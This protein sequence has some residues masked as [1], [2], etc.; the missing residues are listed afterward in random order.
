MEVKL[1]GR[2]AT[3]RLGEVVAQLVCAGDVVLL[4]GELGAGKTTFVRGLVRGLGSSEEVTSPTFTLRHEYDTTPMLTHVDCWRLEDVSE[5][6]DL[7]LD[8]VI[9]EGGLL[10]IEWGELA[11][12]RFGDAALSVVLVD[13]DAGKSR[14]ATLELD[15]PAWVKRAA[16][17]HEALAA[18]G[19]EPIGGVDA[20]PVP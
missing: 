9:S 13:A 4:E 1:E 8:E 16:S 5:L 15:N 7:G 10:A 14:V 12:P 19:L 17:F 6:D 2:G 3:E 11:A 20:S 18:A